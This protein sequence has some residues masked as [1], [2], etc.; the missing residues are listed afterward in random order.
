VPGAGIDPG[1]I[2]VL[3]HEQIIGRYVVARN[4]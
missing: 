2:V 4:Q 3:R 1:I